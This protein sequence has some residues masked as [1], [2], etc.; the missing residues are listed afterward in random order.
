[1]KKSILLLLI[2][3]TA[4]T[5]AMAEL[6]A[7]MIFDSKGK[8]VSFSKML[9]EIVRNDIVLFGE[10]HDN[11][12]SHWLQLELTRSLHEV[13]GSNLILA[14]EM[15]EAD[16][17]LILDEY[18]TGK[19]S[20]TRF[21]EE[22]RL[23]R[24]YKTDYKPLVKFA[25]EN[26]LKFVASNIP[27]RYASMVAWGG[28]EVLESLSEEARSYIAPLPIEYDPELPG[29]KKMLDM[30][31][32]GKPT[33]DFLPKAQAIKDA[34]MAHFMSVNFETG[35]QIIHYHG[36]YHSDF[37]EGIYWYLR[38]LDGEVNI[39]TIATVTQDDVKK[40]SEESMGRA[41]FIIVVP[42]TMTRTY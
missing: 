5:T 32:M 34:T 14:A 3:L 26:Q 1:M 6:P 31:G 8:K 35:K 33:N 38:R 23:W 18:L 29:Y 42:S 25:K 39:V 19:I 30:G 28:F 13:K 40:L 7:Y 41:D 22:I 15:F 9:K 20:E 17:Q 2:I 4:F 36:T 10:F 21:E 27:R 16:N 37:Y 11:P 24:N 12:I